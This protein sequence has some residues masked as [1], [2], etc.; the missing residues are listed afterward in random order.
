MKLTTLGKLN[1]SHLLI[2][3]AL[4]M[5]SPFIA[6]ADNDR[7]RSSVID[8]IVVT[9]INELCGAPVFSL[10]IP[11]SLPPTAHATN[12]GEYNP[13]GPLPITLSATNCSDD[14]V[15]ATN[16]DADFLSKLGIPDAN[17]GIKNIPLRQNFV[18]TGQDGSRSSLP[19]LSEARK[20]GLIATRSNP[21]ETI[22]LG[23]W[24][25]GK[26]TLRL[27]CKTNGKATVEARFKNLIPNGLYSMWAAW[28]APP[29]GPPI[30]PVPLG[31]IPNAVV[32]D[33]FGNASF[34]RELATCPLNAT[35]DGSV[36]L[37]VTLAYHSDS[38]LYGAIPEIGALPTTIHPPVGPSFITTFVPGVATHD[39]IEFPINA[40]VIE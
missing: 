32:P 18:I 31:G 34:F 7:D 39:A 8:G 38:S 1:R 12:L 33:R 35:E 9:G 11:P 14:I 40:T 27:K 19:A 21:D 6:N 20:S 23:Q 26:G 3:A 13:Y 2:T 36:M 17:P 25:D 22:T 30:A 10:P 28:T 5:V 4:G 37:F 24:L 15:L 16:T 29:P